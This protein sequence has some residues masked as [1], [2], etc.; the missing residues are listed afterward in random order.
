MTDHT[1][2]HQDGAAFANAIND[3]TDVIHS[4]NVDAGWWIDIPQDL[5][6]K[7]PHMLKYVVPV[8]LALV[9]SEVS[10]ALEGFRKN[11][12]DDHLPNRLMIEVELADAI[13]RILDLAGALNL[14]VGGALVEKFNYNQHRPDHKPENRNA[15]GGKS[16]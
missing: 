9:H 14:D 11:L 4:A 6:L 5:D 13:I 3:I 10:E 1:I 12:K 16:V 15:P 8:K 2:N 7:S